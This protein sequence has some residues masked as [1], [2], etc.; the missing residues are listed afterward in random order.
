MR[1]ELTKEEFLKTNEFTKDLRAVKDG[2]IFV[3]CCS[4]M[5]GS[6]GSAGCVELMAKQFYPDKFK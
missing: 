6:A 4:D 3:A 2:K 1:R 5:Q